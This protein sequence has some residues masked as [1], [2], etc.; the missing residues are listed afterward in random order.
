MSS[1]IYNF[2]LDSQYTDINRTIII[3]NYDG[4]HLGHKSIINQANII[5]KLSNNSLACLTFTPHSLNILNP[6]S[7]ITTNLFNAPDK[8]NRLFANNI[9]EIFAINKASFFQLT[10]RQFI[11]QVLIKQLRCCNLVIG[12]DFRFGLN[13]LGDLN[14][15][16]EYENL[17]YFKLHIIDT[18]LD[19]SLIKISSTLIREYL[20]KGDLDQVNKLLGYSYY[21][22][23]KI[24]KGEKLSAS[25]SDPTININ[26]ANVYQPKYGIYTGLIKYKKQF[27]QGLLNIGVTPRFLVD[28]PKLEMFV[29]NFNPNLY[30]D[31]YDETV[32][33][34]PKK[35]LREK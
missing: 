7:K 9:A 32:K 22:T 34:I 17:G 15:L 3:G 26:I 12:K 5:A 31:L 6:N 4:V 14:L 21:I 8:Y 11:E 33:I 10:A 2:E 19:Q 20:L 28:K 25:L 18:F 29:F 24:I 27:Y 23:G 30:G 16:L 1:I 35:Y 13:R